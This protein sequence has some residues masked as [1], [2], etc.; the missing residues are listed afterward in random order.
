MKRRIHMNHGTN[1]Q[2]YATESSGS[3]NGNNC[4]S[5]CGACSGDSS[6]PVGG[7]V[8]QVIGGVIT[9]GVVIIDT[10]GNPDD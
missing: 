5:G 1:V 2:M 10:S 9:L 6:S 3:S 7:D 8:A 4:A